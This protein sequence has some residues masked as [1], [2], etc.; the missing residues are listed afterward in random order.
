MSVPTVEEMQEHCASIG[1]ELPRNLAQALSSW[2][3]YADLRG[4]LVDPRPGTQEFEDVRGAVFCLARVVAR[5]HEDA[6]TEMGL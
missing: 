1:R 3:M 6:N 5:G 2:A 4:A